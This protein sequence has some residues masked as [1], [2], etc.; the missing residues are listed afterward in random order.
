[1]HPVTEKHYLQRLHGGQ[2]AIHRYFT[3]FLTASP[4][5][6]IS[7]AFLCA[8]SVTTPRT[9]L[10]VD[11]LAAITYYGPQ[12]ITHCATFFVQ[13]GLLTEPASGVYEWVH[14]YL[15]TAFR[16]YAAT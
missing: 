3:L 10:H 11:A 1:G 6:D 14:D 8:L 2:G 13:E 16:D 9:A 7:T 4:N 5:R 12:D 15:A